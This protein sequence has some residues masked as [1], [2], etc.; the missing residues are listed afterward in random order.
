MLKALV[1]TITELL[2]S[3]KS[4]YSFIAAI[5]ACILHLYFDVGVSDALM[6]VSPLGL[7]TAA[8]AHVDAAEAKQPRAAAPDAAPPTSANAVPSA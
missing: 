7:A 4:A 1:R 8:Q 3:K 2:D 5:G 6:L